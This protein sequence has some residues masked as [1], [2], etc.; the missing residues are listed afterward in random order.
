MQFNTLS[1]GNLKV[2]YLCARSTLN[3]RRFYWEA[4]TAGSKGYRGGRLD[5]MVTP[6]RGGWV[7]TVVSG[8]AWVPVEGVW[9]TDLEARAQAEA[10]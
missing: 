2:A 10:A 5:A 8:G 3:P 1:W 9:P 7:A 4:T 6:H